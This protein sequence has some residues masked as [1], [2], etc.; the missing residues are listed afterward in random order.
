MIGTIRVPS[1]SI[2]G[3]GMPACGEDV[4]SDSAA[5]C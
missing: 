5:V 1:L 4:S 2:I 3:E